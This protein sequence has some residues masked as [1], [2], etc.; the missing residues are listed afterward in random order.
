[1]LEVVGG[2]PRNRS[3]RLVLSGQISTHCCLAGL[4]TCPL[5]AAGA[6]Q[7]LLCGRRGSK[8][9]PEVPRLKSGQSRGRTVTGRA[10]RSA[11]GQMGRTGA[12]G[13]A[14]ACRPPSASIF[15]SVFWASGP[16]EI[17]GETS[18]EPVCLDGVRKGK[19]GKC[20]MSELI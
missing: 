12:R 6:D 3:R 11:R 4:R 2:D 8:R 15:P 14:H 19:L 9:P 16:W 17:I 10:E 1:M 18:G 7:S 13:S 20:R 5:P